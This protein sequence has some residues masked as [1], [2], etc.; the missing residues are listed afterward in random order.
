[1]FSSKNTAP[2]L[3]S[4]LLA[5]AVSPSVWAEQDPHAHHQ[6]PP[7]EQVDPHAHHNMPRSAADDPHAPQ[8]MSPSETDDR[9]AH[10]GKMNSEMEDPHAH[11][12]MNKAGKPAVRFEPLPTPTE[13]DMAVAFPDLDG[14][15]LRKHMA[16]P[17]MWNLLMDQLEQRQADEG[18]FTTWDL[19]GWLGND[20]HRLWLRSEGERSNQGTQS[21]ELSLLYGRPL[22]RW[23]D[24]VI[25]LRQNFKPGPSQ[26]F[27]AFGL[28][29]L[30]P[31]WFELE[32]TAYL[33][34]SG[35]LEGRIEAEYELLL[36]NRVIL[37]PL[38]ELE[39]SS[40][41]D[42]LRGTAS[43]MN[44]LETGLRLRYEIRREFAPYVGVAWE[45]NLGKAARWARDRGESVSETTWLLGIRFWY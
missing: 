9:H 13:K 16:T 32:A 42:R 36:S 26:T 24:G 11:H 15:D 2:L 3:G 25:G 21:A 38:I 35:Q 7:A 20:E 8:S 10:H 30:A 12:R 31:Y 41:S 5:L 1:M 39:A 44:K 45:R 4:V 27:L 43:G 14:M 6:M 37:Q 28:Q 40:E 18:D 34:E 33:G 17:V 29:G 19:G 23:W 22:A